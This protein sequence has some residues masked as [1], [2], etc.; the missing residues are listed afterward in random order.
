MGIHERKKREKVERKA[1]ILRCT[2]ELLLEHGIDGVSMQD[3]AKKA[4]L[5]KGTLYLYFPSKEDLYRE[6][7]EEAASRFITYFYTQIRP[8]LSALE[9]IKLH[10]RCYL[11]MF[12]ASYDMIIIFSMKHYI[13][14]AFPFTPFEENFKTEG[15]DSSRSPYIFYTMIRDMIQQGIGEGTFDPLVNAGV[16]ARTM[17]SLFSYIVE[18]VA[19]MPEPKRNAQ[20]IIKEVKHSFEILLRGIAQEGIDRSLL[21]LPDI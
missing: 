21:L 20:I 1:L 4:E 17:L 6:I 8:G 18:N 7:C 2:K 12:G 9:M 15:A 3:I 16:V 11:D 10:W 13:A 5:S 19:K 14:P